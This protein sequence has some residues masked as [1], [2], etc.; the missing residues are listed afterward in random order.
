MLIGT[1]YRLATYVIWA[2]FCSSLHRYKVKTCYRE[3]G[4]HIKNQVNTVTKLFVPKFEH[5][6]EKCCH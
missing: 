6:N 1:R 2:A 3:C 4:S 5:S